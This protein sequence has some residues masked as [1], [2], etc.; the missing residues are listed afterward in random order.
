MVAIK[1]VFRRSEIPSW[2][3]PRLVM[4]VAILLSGGWAEPVVAQFREKLDGVGP[5]FGEVHV[6]RWVAGVIVRATGGSCTG[7]RAYIPIPTDW[8]EQDVTTLEE[9]ISPGVKVSY[10]MVEGGVRQ[11]VVEIPFLAAGEEAKALITTE[12][13]RRVILPPPDTSV[14]VLPERRK[15]PRDVLPFLAVSPG[16]EVTNSKIQSLSKQLL[17][18][19]G[20]AWE[21]VERI[22]DWV[23]DNIKY[24]EGP[25]KGALAALSDGTGDCEEMTSLFIALCRAGGIPARTV[26]IPGHAYAEFYLMDKEGKG[27]WFP[28]QLAGS[29]AFGEMNE[30]RPVLQKGDNFR[31][32]SNPRDRKRY[33][34]EE[35]TGTGGRPQVEFVR[36]LLVR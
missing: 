27:Y 28:C 3:D 9:D 18:A 14:F 16:I 17:S 34:A 25:F 8:P 1:H 35:L 5:Q 32:S 31:S 20:T 23:R 24:Q 36:R 22:Y 19:E 4:A 7:I 13:R 15:L 26:W 2:I 21:K 30:A 10:R 6:Q 11:M 12:T 33:L 29:R